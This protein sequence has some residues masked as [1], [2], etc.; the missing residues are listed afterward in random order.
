MRFTG[1]LTDEG[2]LVLDGETGEVTLVPR[3]DGPPRVRKPA[4]TIAAPAPVDPFDLEVVSSFPT[5]IALAYERFLREGDPRHRGKLLVD[6]FTTTLKLWAFLAAAEYLRAGSVDDAA[7][8]EL[9]VR[10]FQRPLLSS[11]HRMV[12]HGVAALARAGVEPFAPEL[13]E[14]Y[15]A[16]EGRSDRVTVRVRYEDEA[17]RTKLRDLKLGKISALIRYRNGLAHGFESDPARAGQELERHAALLGDVLRASRFLG[18]YPLVS[19]R[20]APSGE[21]RLRRWLGPAPAPEEDAP[22]WLEPRDGPMFF[23]DAGRRRALGLRYL[24][25]TTS[26]EPPEP[27]LFEGNTKSAVLYV[28]SSGETIETQRRARDLERELAARAGRADPVSRKPTL[29][30]LRSAA[31]RRTRASIDRLVQV[32]AYLRETAIRRAAVEACFEEFDLGDYRGLV[33]AADGGAGK[34]TVM[35]QR[36]EEL[37]SRGHVVLFYRASAL[38]DADLGAQILRDLAARDRHLDELFVE[39]EPLMTGARMYVLI[40]AVDE[41]A[42]DPA[43]L[44]RAVDQLVAQALVH[45]W[46]RVVASVRT[47]AYERFPARSRFGAHEDA[48]Y[49]CV[50]ETRGETAVRTPLVRLSPYTDAEL[51]EV[52]ERYRAYRR[53]DPG[54]PDDPGHHVFRPTTEFGDLDPYGGAMALMRDPLMMR[55]L[56]AAHHRR[57]LPSE[58]SHDEAMRLFVAHVVEEPERRAFLAGLVRELD[59]RENDTLPRDALYE[60]PALAASLKSAH[61]DGAY[62]QLLDLGVLFEE[63][64]GADCTV[65]FAHEALFHHLLAEHHA[66]RIETASELGD[67]IARTARFPALRAA[68]VLVVARAELELRGSW[69]AEVLAGAPDETVA[70]L[71][72]ALEHVGRYR[73]EELA[74]TLSALSTDARAVRVLLDLFDRLL[75]GGQIDAA[76]ETIESATARA[77][78]LEHPALLASALL[79]AA[80]LA[81]LRGRSAE[82][83]A[84]VAES[85]A[86]AITA[87]EELLVH[88]VELVRARTLLDAMQ[89]DDADACFSRALE[90]LRAKERFDAA[91]EA[92]RGRALVAG[93]RGDPARQLEWLEEARELSERAEDRWGTAKTLNSMAKLLTEQRRYREAEETFHRAL[94]IQRSLGARSSI[95]LTELNLGSVY[96][97]ELADPTRAEEH[98][99]RALSMFEALGH[100]RGIAAVLTNLAGSRFVRGELDGA[101]DLIERAS[102]LWDDCGDRANATNA[103]YLDAMIVLDRGG[104][105]RASVERH[106]RLS[107][108]ASSKCE[109]L[110]RAVLDA[111]ML[112]H[113]G[114]PIAELADALALVDRCHD[115]AGD[116]ATIDDGAA[117]AYR[118][119]V[120]RASS[121]GEHDRAARWAVRALELAAAAPVRFR[122]AFAARARVGAIRA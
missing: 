2:L 22:E 42:S 83:A 78:T 12:H 68:L 122:E 6:T 13:R 59:R 76:R 57:H 106:R 28:R 75:L 25:D 108:G 103:A 114:A 31:E 60:I 64:H 14:A 91:A 94:A 119:A 54:D 95:A 5:P 55:L 34:T 102:R 100:S 84:Y 19:A 40:D 48:R 80:N 36:A 69:I 41:H 115:A 24:A 72:D 88:S 79:R 15:A 70:I 117:F 17:G 65:A 46:I 50:E 93:R 18:R 44:A 16:L 35:I 27:L 62:A 3:G 56:M 112:A 99:G 61:K 8:E 120:E 38:T 45:P 29:D 113:G 87:G 51:R 92:C 90:G 43:A 7:V 74:P 52:Y 9:L 11:W 33:L 107:E 47:H 85:H 104:D 109:A 96:Y 81:L 20:R 97:R 116:T 30:A 49:L 53:R 66:P 32:G 39:L 121:A 86:H 63:W 101:A 111:R 110:H 73:K 58:I 82:A 89:L 77:R 1:F 37:L 67:R 23:L 71:R 118:D 98:W 26:E 4:G 10:D 105:P 21:L